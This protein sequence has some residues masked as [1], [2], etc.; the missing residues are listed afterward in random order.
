[1]HCE[2]SDV[3]PQRAQP[4]TVTVALAGLFDSLS[5]LSVGSLPHLGSPDWWLIILLFSTMPGNH[6]LHY[7]LIQLNFSSAGFWGK[8]F[9]ICSACRRSLRN[10]L[11]SWFS[12]VTSSLH[13]GFPCGSAG[14]ESACRMG[15]QGS[16][17]GLG[18]FPGEEKGYPLQYLAHC[19][20]RATSLLLHAY[21]QNLYCC[22]EHAQA[23]TCPHPDSN[24][25][26]LLGRVSEYSVLWNCFSP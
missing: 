13:L 17:P 2:T 5:A 10:C 9:E 19:P 25:F 1:M 22:W 24:K 23:W 3:A 26:S 6:K 7:S 16:I 8:S 11:F 15:D 4:W 21:H 14:K 12:L 18:K 20:F